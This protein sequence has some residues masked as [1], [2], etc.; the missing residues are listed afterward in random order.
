MPAAIINPFTETRFGDTK[1]SLAFCSRDH[2]GLS[3]IRPLPPNEIN[4]IQDGPK[5]GRRSCKE[6]RRKERASLFAGQKIPQGA[7]TSRSGPRVI[8]AVPYRAFLIPPVRE[9]LRHS[10][11]PLPTRLARGQTRV[12]VPLR[13]ILLS[14]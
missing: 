13:G 2:V 7:A 4:A 14:H 1:T 11:Q 6:F 3:R 5:R 9:V 10:V 12:L 8:T